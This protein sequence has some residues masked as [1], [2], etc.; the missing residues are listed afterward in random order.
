MP[1]YEQW[2]YSVVERYD[3]DGVGGMP[4]LLFPVRCYEIGS[5]FSRCEP[6]PVAD[7]LEML[8]HAYAAAHRANGE[9]VVAHAA[10][11]TTLAF[12][13][14]PRATEYETAVARVPD[15]SHSLADIRQVLDRRDIFDVINVHSLGDPYEIEAIVAWLDYEMAQRGYHKPII[16][17]DTATTPF[18]AWGPATACHRAPSQ[19]G[20]IIPPATEA[21]RCRPADYFTRL[22]LYC[23]VRV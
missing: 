5:E 1:A 16:L 13:D 3:A 10:F 9:V 23:F 17:S 14:D 2:I 12:V 18:I 11:L 22:V 15:Q 6:E 8:E 21:D 4:G 20:R 19:M 7:Y